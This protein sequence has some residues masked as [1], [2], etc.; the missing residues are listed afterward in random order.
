MAIYLDVFYL[1]YHVNVELTEE[2]V[3]RGEINRVDYDEEPYIAGESLL[4]WID[5][6][7]NA[8]GNTRSCWIGNK[9]QLVCMTWRDADTSDE[10]EE[11]EEEYNVE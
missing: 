4:R 8:P 9:K 2:A 6:Y 5:A 11:E 3:K 7:S 1:L 10:E